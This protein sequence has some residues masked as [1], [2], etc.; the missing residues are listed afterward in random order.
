M[1]L[2]ILID[3]DKYKAG[4]EIEIKDSPEAHQLI[5][6]GVASV[7]EHDKPKRNA[8]KGVMLPG[9]KKEE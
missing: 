7:L 8:K 4:E 9:E 6:T 5:G 3:H 2:L 1:K